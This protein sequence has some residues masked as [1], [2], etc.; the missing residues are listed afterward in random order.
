VIVVIVGL[1]GI[2]AA[3]FGVRASSN[4]DDVADFTL[5]AN[6]GRWSPDTI[7]VQQGDKVR[8]HLTSHDVV[9]G[10]SL[11]DY[12]IDV[13]VIYPG[14][15]TEVEFVAD[16]AGTF[17]FECT[18]W[19]NVDHPTMRGELVVESAGTESQAEE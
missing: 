11:P 16:E 19:C 10:F 18:V 7:R 8:L 12:G 13:D 3:T 17:Q 2:P 14:K 4:F 9:H 1:V 6:D 15:V 5:V